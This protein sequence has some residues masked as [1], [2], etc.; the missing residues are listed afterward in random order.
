MSTNITPQKIENR[1]NSGNSKFWI[2][3]EQT[4]YLHTQLF[5]YQIVE[6]Y[7]EI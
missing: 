4:T 3:F 1:I 6:E 2:L 5:M 7:E